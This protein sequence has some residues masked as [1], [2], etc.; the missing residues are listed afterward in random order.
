[1]PTPITS[2]RDLRSLS[3]PHVGRLHLPALFM[4]RVI[5]GTTWSPDGEQVAFISNISGR[6]NLW[7]VPAAGGWPV[8]LTVSEQRQSSPRWSPDGRWIAYISDYDGNEQWDL[9]VVSPRDGEV[10]NLTR[11]PEIAEEDPAWSP[12]GR[13]LA[14]IA[15]PRLGSTFEIETVEVDSGQI[16]AVTRGTAKDLGN[17]HPLWSPDGRRL[18]YT[19][20]HATGKDS[21][22]YAVDLATGVHRALTPHEGEFNFSA[23]AWSPDG[24]HLLMASNIVN[25]HENVG[26]LDVGSRAITWLTREAWDVSPG[27]FSPSGDALTWQVN[28]DGNSEVMLFQR[29]SGSAAVLP[30]PDGVNDFG[31]GGQAFSRDGRELLCYHNGPTTP[32][33]VWV[34]SLETD[35]A[36]QITHS[37][38]CGVQPADMVEPFLVHYPSTDGQWRISAFVYLPHNLERDGTH[39][40]VVHIHGGPQAQTVNSFQRIV[41]V[42][43]NRGYVVIAPNYRGS[44]GYG[45]AF[46]DANRFDM[47]GGDLADVIAA[48]DWL[49]G[50]GYVDAHRMAV[51]GGSYGGYLTMMALT[52]AP[53]RW[54]AGVAIVP[55]VNWFTELEHEDPLLREYDLATMGDPVVNAA[56]YRDRSPIFFVDQ[57]EAPVLLLAGA[58]DPRCPP[59][60]ARQV[61]TAIQQRGGIAELKIFENE[62]HGFARIENQIAAYQQVAEFLERHLGRDK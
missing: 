45:K 24:C 61:A 28:R 44:T 37:L 48:A 27:S 8:Q 14:Y 51:M 18:A 52:K 4:T 42:L 19:Q 49:A 12:D 6:Q 43:V 32:Q 54:A 7:V 36:R 13:H 50:S 62:G 33:D 38:T 56:L 22:V 40:A 23:A 60:E 3:R 57:V 41:Q 31:G 39:P 21:N 5:G 59:D 2:P 58:Q 1:M 20:A 10:R 15:K 11:T 46:Q 35:A 25:G 17:F 34:Y 53:R 55:F 30:L 47:G 29:L 26:L 16:R 9:F